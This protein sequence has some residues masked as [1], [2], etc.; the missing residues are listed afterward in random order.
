MYAYILSL[1]FIVVNQAVS[2]TPTT[3]GQVKSSPN[4]EYKHTS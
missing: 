4:P 2:N 1:L 3:Y